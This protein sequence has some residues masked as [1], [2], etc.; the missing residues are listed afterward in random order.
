M[1]LCN[2][3]EKMWVL[4]SVD[5][6]RSSIEQEDFFFSGNECPVFSVCHF[7]SSIFH[8]KCNLVQITDVE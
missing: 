1:N 3:L 7:K 2:S 5:E 4:L 6:L 8:F